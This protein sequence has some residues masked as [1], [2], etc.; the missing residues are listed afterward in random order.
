MTT[1]T[2]DLERLQEQP[3][4]PLWDE[5]LAGAAERAEATDPIVL[6]GLSPTDK[7]LWSGGIRRRRSVPI[8][9][10][11]GLNGW[12]KTYA[13]VRDTLPDLAMGRKVLSTVALLDPHTGNPHPNYIPFR[14]WSQLLELRDGVALMDE[15]TGMMDSRDSGMPKKV[16]IYIPQM[17]RANSPVR[18]TGINW[19]NSDKRLRQITQAVAMCHGYMPNNSLVRSE[20]GAGDVLDAIPMWAPNRLFSIVTYDAQTLTSADDGA[21]LAQE[22]EKKKKAKVKN[23]EW[24]WGPGSLAFQCYNTLDSVSTV[25]NSC[26]VIDPETGEVCGGKLTEK[27]CRGHDP[28]GVSRSA[29]RG[30]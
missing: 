18:W 2:H 30:R 10:Y 26:Q 5:L 20:A 11:N 7:R 25:D 8:M 21:Q 12:G 9:G 17:R 28:R 16:R 27:I 4:N 14:T 1:H 6:P 24:V 22:K 19:D 13:M 29:A 23:R 3:S 15:V